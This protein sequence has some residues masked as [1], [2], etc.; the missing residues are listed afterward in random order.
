MMCI[1][2]GL[3]LIY[4]SSMRFIHV[5]AYGCNLFSLLYGSL[6][7]EETTVYL[8]FLLLMDRWVAPRLRFSWIFLYMFFSTQIYPLL[9]HKVCVCSNLA[10]I[11]KTFPKWTFSI[12]CLFL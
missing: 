3:A 6:L 4:L 7:Y 9:G 8:S 10:D 12:L 2:L 11:T 5:I 1:L